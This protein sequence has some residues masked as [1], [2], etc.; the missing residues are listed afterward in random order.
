VG[1]ELRQ[2]HEL[3]ADG[4]LTAFGHSNTNRKLAF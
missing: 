4:R 2:N 1:C 3:H